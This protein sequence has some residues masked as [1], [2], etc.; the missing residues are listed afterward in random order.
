MGK[1]SM[2]KAVGS[3]ETG[4]FGGLLM[5]LASHR[6]LRYGIGW[7]IAS[8]LPRPIPENVHVY[9]HQSYLDRAFQRA[10]RS[11][12]QPLGSKEL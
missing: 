1:Q 2:L 11:Y 8:F 10:D 4:T 5:K 6:L 7:I 12:F 3:S 9:F